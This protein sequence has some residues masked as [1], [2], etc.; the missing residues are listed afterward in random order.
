ML[1]VIG[2]ITM[3]LG[4]VSFGDW[5]GSNRTAVSVMREGSGWL[6]AGYLGARRRASSGLSAGKEKAPPDRSGRAL[7]C[8]AA[9]SLL[10]GSLV[11]AGEVGIL[12][13]FAL[14]GHVE[15][16]VAEVFVTHFLVAQ[17]LV[18]EILVAL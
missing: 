12:E 10:F 9:N 3:R 1:R 18:A 14:V 2:A 8:Q 13:R 11:V 15:R 17:V 7:S 16:F 5:K 4:S 6:R